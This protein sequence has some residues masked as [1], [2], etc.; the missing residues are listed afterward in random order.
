MA[1][2]PAGS[3]KGYSFSK[4]VEKNADLLKGLGTAGV[5]LSTIAISAFGWGIPVEV[6]APLS[7]FLGAIF[8]VGVSAIQFRQ[9]EVKL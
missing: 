7:V 5:S 6:I 1:A 4:Y 3:M 9:S 2:S 8:H